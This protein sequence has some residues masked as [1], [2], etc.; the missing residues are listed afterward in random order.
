M[1]KAYNRTETEVNTATS[2]LSHIF[3]TGRNLVATTCVTPQPP[4]MIYQMKATLTYL[5]LKK[6]G[7][8]PYVCASSS[9]SVCA[10]GEPHRYSCWGHGKESQ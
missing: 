5:H 6:A 1:V 7:S 8:R 3:A 10:L 9:N 4:K 2:E